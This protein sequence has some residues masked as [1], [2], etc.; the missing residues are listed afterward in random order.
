LAKGFASTSVVAEAIFTSVTDSIS[1]Q[2]KALPK[3]A[4]HNVLEKADGLLF[5]KLVDHVAENCADRIETLIRL[6][7]VGQA[8][9]IQQYLLH[10]EDCYCLAELRASL[11]NA[12][13]QRDDLSGQEEVDDFR[14]V[15]LDKRADDTERG[16]TKI[17]KRT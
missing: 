12:E 7:N 2:E 15:V 8:D 14:R 10:D 9:I 17:L 1:E 4:T 6:A 5:D 3:E 11:H 16:K 13:A